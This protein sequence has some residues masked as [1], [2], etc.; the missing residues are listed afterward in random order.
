MARVKGVRYISFRRGG[1]A[2]GRGGGRGEILTFP[3]TLTTQGLSLW[4]LNK[5]GGE[6]LTFPDT[7]SLLCT[8]GLSLW[9][10]FAFGC[11][12]CRCSAARG[13][14]SAP[15]LVRFISSPHH[16]G[17]RWHHSRSVVT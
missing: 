11:G 8:Q 12:T 15:V 10:V 3:D 9:R 16:P 7:R 2:G 17:A 13:L 14:S 5:V 1:A 6:I 4:S